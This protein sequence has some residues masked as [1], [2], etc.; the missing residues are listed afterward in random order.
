[1]K[2]LLQFQNPGPFFHI[3]ILALD[4]LGIFKPDYSLI[5]EIQLSLGATIQ[6]SPCSP[7]AILPFYTI[8]PQCFTLCFIT[9]FSYATLNAP[10]SDLCCYFKY[11][12]CSDGVT[13]YTSSEKFSFKF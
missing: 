10:L 5:L 1:M 9:E 13:F 11:P 8:A 2:G 12:S 4:F 6:L 3:L 7:P